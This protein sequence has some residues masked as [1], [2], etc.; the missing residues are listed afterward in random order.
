MSP[1]QSFYLYLCAGI[2]AFTCVAYELLLGSYATFLM[3]ASVFQYS[4]VI[5]LM[6][7]SMGIGAFLAKPL[8]K[9]HF[10]TFL[11]VETLLSWSAILAVPLMYF[12][13]SLNFAPTKV[14]IFFV[15]IMGSGI[16]M[17]IPLLSGLN[18]SQQSLTQIL[19]FDYLGGF[20]GGILFPII[21]FPY[22]G[23]F[24]IAAGLGLLN[25][26]IGLSFFWSFRHNL[27]RRRTLWG[28]LT[29]ITVI[30]CLT[31]TIFAEKLRI[32]MESY[33]F[34]ISKN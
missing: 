14:L 33:F 13:F 25:G 3:G 12:S 4:L 24:Q 10:E 27:N 21:L 16:G 26:I 18:P 8:S 1:K 30:A 7:L 20:L 22:F 28:I 19:F 9:N 6:M 31:E 32:E 2:V 34:S 29:G 15:L 11:A 23:F 17:E 5:S